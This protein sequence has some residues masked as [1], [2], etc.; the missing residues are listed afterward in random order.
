MGDAARFDVV[1]LGASAGGETAI[2]TILKELPP[3]FDVPLVVM[4][5]LSPE[6]SFV[7]VYGPRV[8][9]AVEWAGEQSVLAARKVLVCPPRSFVELL[10]DRSLRLHPCEAGALHRPID[11][12]LQSAARSFAHRAIGV[13]LTGMGSDGAAG[14][15]E[16]QAAG[17]QVLV[18]SAAS[19]EYPDMPRVAIAA[20][21]ATLVVPLCDLAQVIAELVAGT[22]R[23]RPRSE[24]QAVE[25][26]FGGVGDIAA[27]AREIDWSRTPLG[28]VLG[29]P[30]E[31]RLMA[32][33]AMESPYPMAVWWG[34][35]LVQ[36]Y[37]EP[38]RRF[39]G[40]SKHPEALGRPACE[41]WPEIWIDIGPMVER[42]MQQGV[43]V[44]GEDFLMVIDRHGYAEEVYV[45]FAYSPIRDIAGTVVGV[46][47]TVSE[48]TQRVVAER[49]LNA[50]RALAERIRGAG[51]PR[52]ACEQAAAALASVPLDLAFAL[53]YLFDAP[54]RQATLAG[55]AG[56]GAG[57]SAAPHTW[58]LDAPH[59]AWPLQRLLDA[60]ARAEPAGVL[61][62]DLARRLPELP[63]L[64]DAHAGRPAPR[65]AL[66][67]PLRLAAEEAP[68]GALVAALNPQRPLDDDYRS[69]LG[70]V[71]Q[72]VN[73]GLIEA[74][75]R[76][77]EHERLERLAEVDRAKTEF[78][79]NV[80]H[81]FRTPLTLL[82][83][84]L[85]EM[86]RRREELPAFL[87]GEIDAA[88][89]SSRRLLRL[90]NDLLDF[91]Q[92]E[93]R[94]LHTVL[95]PTD[96]AAL[97]S[98]I[99]SAFRSAI[100]S[101]GL[102][103][104]VEC[105]GELPSVPVNREMWEKVV[106]NLLANALKF[107]FMGEI[108][109]AL[110]A[111]SLHAELVVADTGIGIPR[112]ELPNLFKRFH[113]VHGARSRTVEG[114]GI[115]LSIVHDLVWRMGGQLRVNSVEHRGTSFTIWMPFKSVRQTLEP[116]AAP[117]AI[118][119]ATRLALELADEA[120]RWV[121]D[122][123]APT[124]A[125]LDETFGAPG[126]Q[127]LRGVR[128]LVADDNADLRDYLRRLL[129]AYWS[130]SVVADGVAALAAAREHRPDLILA[131]VM[132]PGLDGFALLRAVRADEALK[133]TPVVLLTARAG[134]ETAIEG[135][136]AGA[137]DYLS[138]PFS[139]RELVARVGGQLE[140]SR[141]RRRAE[142]L[143][144]FLVRFSEQ[145]RGLTDARA[146]AQT[147]CRMALEQLGVERA[148]WAEV[149]WSTRDYVIAGA[150]HA[151]GVAVTDDRFPL[152]AWEPLTSLHLAGKP[153]VV[154]D[155]QADPRVP[156]H[157]KAGYAQLEVGSDVAAPVVAEGRLRC[158]LAVNQRLPRRWMPE[159]VALIQGIAV[160]C[161]AEVERS[162][163]EAALRESEAKYR[164][165][166][167]EMDEAYAVV[168]VMADSASHWSDLR[169]VE[170][171]RAF[172][173]HT[174][175]ADPVGKTATELLRTPNP[176]W[177][178]IFGRV[179]ETG[180]SVRLEDAE[181]TLERSFDLNV[182]RLG[183]EGSRRV[184]VLFTDV[185]E[186][187]RHERRQAF[188]LEI[189]DA[190]RALPDEPSIKEQT[191]RMLA[192]HLRLDRCWISEVSES[193][194]TSTVGPEHFRPDLAPMAGEFRLSDFPETVSLLAAQPLVVHDVAGDARFPASEKELLA[195]LQL[196]A[197]LAAPVRKGERHVI[198]AL[199][200]AMATPRQ[201]SDGERVLLEEVAERMWAAVERARGEAATARVERHAAALIERMGD[202]HCVLDRDFRIQRVNAATE[203]LLGVPRTALV[204]RSHWDV[205]PASVDA[206]VGRVFRRVVAE[207][208]EQHLTH[209]YTGEGYDLHI[210]LDAYPT[211]EG[212]V[213]MFW[214]D[215][216]K[217]VRA[218][219]AL[220]ESEEKYRALFSQMDEAYA[221]VEVMADAAG[222]WSDFLFL[223]V[224]AAFMRHT[225]M[226]YPV[227][228]T[229]TQLLG[230][231]NPR[232][233]QLYGQA[234]QTGEP[235]RLEESELTLDRV[236]DL[237]IFRL[238][239][240]G[241]R[242]VAVLFTDVT[243]RRRAQDALRE[244][245]R[246]Y[247]LLFENIGEG[248]ALADMI[249]SEDGQPLDWRYLEVNDAWSLQT[250]VP[251]SQT[252]GRTAREVN[253]RIEPD[254]IETY[255]R[256]VRTGQPVSYENYAAG[257][258][259]W[260]ETAAFKHSENCFGLLFR[261]VTQRREAAA[262]LRASEKRQAFLLQLGDALRPLDDPAA[263][264]AEA[265]RVVGE[266][267]G[268]GRAYYVEVDEQRGEYVVEAEWH[269][270]G[271]PSPARR[272]P[273][274]AWPMP[275]L[276]DGQP[277]AVRDVDTDPAMPDGQRA[278]YQANGIGAC[279]VVPLVK[280]GRLVAMLAANETA[281]RDWTVAEVGMLQE[282]AECTWAAVERK[283]AEGALRDSE[284]Q[285]RAIANLVPDLLWRSDAQGQAQWYSERWFDYTGLP[286]ALAL[287][288]GWA[289]I[290]HPEDLPATQRQWQAAVRRRRPY[291]FEHRLRR[292]DG[293][294]R[295]FLSRAA[296]LFDTNGR[297]QQWFGSV[298]DIHE[299][300]YARELL[301]QRV[302]ERT[303]E[304]E[305]AGELRRQLLARVETLQDDERRRIARE[306]HDSLGQLLSALLLSIAGLRQRLG[307][308]AVAGHL[309]KLQQLLETADHELDRIVFTLRP[310]A[311]EDS[312]LA[313]AVAAYV[314]TWSGLC[315]QPVDLLV[316]GLQ[317]QRLPARVEAAVF[318]VI[319]EA[320]NNVAKHAQARNVSVVLER[321]GGELV[322]SVEDDGAGFDTEQVAAA[323]GSRPSWGLL[324]MRERVEALDGSFDIESR[325][326][327]GTTVLL[328]VPLR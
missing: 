229:A 159:E 111:L 257:F 127:A 42:V 165:L 309:G 304:L 246:R 172:A 56:L 215:V 232:W 118:R 154:D 194:G 65:Q 18:Q 169:F 149:D 75:A 327:Q 192:E 62:D 250:G 198:C 167:D 225:G 146:V 50:L 126:G 263:I 220:R 315:G 233:A 168:E 70:L 306:L 102:T 259:K 207:G 66:L 63:A 272:Y 123:P 302:K 113:R 11:R 187:K 157:V 132:M 214:R 317:G 291:R 206:P 129:G 295:W 119:P 6:S 144:A 264:Q 238:G 202:A 61:L 156:A 321:L 136:L 112:Q 140:L 59:D 60:D 22:P 3:D 108:S 205:F 91:S 26:V 224:N 44:G 277:W 114:S 177:A 178:Q 222:R 117:A 73:A 241:S 261:D 181:P 213:A 323:D 43:A 58:T 311:L 299:Q 76:Q 217:R 161:W 54:R 93:A 164:A 135:L 34:P 212:G 87:A 326:G 275:W 88:A 303:R 98:D 223:E 35:E 319:Q 173:K 237:N 307:D 15:R 130:V 13:V 324:G 30:A 145:V 39:L 57:S 255:A 314:G 134:E 231:P 28:P 55:A 38:W 46:L 179:A 27:L 19:A 294:Y 266:Q 45:T 162:R 9:L 115:G 85:E 40:A 322:A 21:A 17:A 211:D 265:A 77:L 297:V 16:L 239:G 94:G 121:S 200:A 141:S 176:R 271:V 235:I 236:F 316:N 89:R 193:Q 128:L 283:R 290:I 143:N 320:L 100:E 258:G 31:L 298:T 273:L 226:P 148:Y 29:W 78:F 270:G 106:S 288:Q 300:R 234:A 292:H 254:W 199:A 247:R 107:T 328:R 23:P 150:V 185:T 289:G 190:L 49:R 284:M 151:P 51:T 253:P 174:G 210:E 5:H 276:A 116:V 195:G 84:P 14:A 101:A 86:Q 282:T 218:E 183:G 285:M 8:P 32:R 99:A 268:T 201:W 33:T 103:L 221:V 83:A 69:F 82:L 184:A 293:E 74:R 182:F 191:V 47:N 24:L 72:H 71:A 109:V 68:I 170:V 313:D 196:R 20:G 286:E 228:R 53:L 124:P 260:F 248:F 269:R 2:L 243:E 296:P 125:P 240:E 242:R 251:V 97:T 37:N 95:E 249:W 90:V 12:L 204:G 230:T 245:E 180:R 48:T 155:T 7:E 160:R 227:G 189:S 267:L 281:P 122:A 186:R 166:F 92:I 79:A 216:T 197:L 4:Q 52:Q 158:S 25:R 175:M 1:V 244:S 171:N 36:L 10:P 105:P 120:A 147:A 262:K 219:E 110:R 256:V 287:G 104:R 305:R 279:L 280:N 325:P 64:L 138:K 318:R 163:A 308:A 142:E 131:D 312:G 301:E 96:L 153:V 274:A 252:V 209:H 81:E 139:A 137:D 133:H 310:T 152:D 67:L 80:S 278:S 41:T 203:R 208:I 188:L